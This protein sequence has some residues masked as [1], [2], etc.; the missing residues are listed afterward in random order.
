MKRPLASSCL[1]LWHIV[2]LFFNYSCLK[3]RKIPYTIKLESQKYN[4]SYNKLN[5]YKKYIMSIL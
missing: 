3:Q 1:Y 2:D 5:T 4:A